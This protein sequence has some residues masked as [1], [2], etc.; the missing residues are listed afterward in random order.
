MAVA[1]ESEMQKAV[2]RHAQADMARTPAASI[3]PAGAEPE[4]RSSTAPTTSST[5]WAA[6]RQGLKDLQNIVLGAWG[7]T[8]EEPGSIANPTPLEVYQ[9]KHQ[10]TTAPEAFSQETGYAAQL[11][12]MRGRGSEDRSRGGLSR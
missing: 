2:T 4:G 12:Q 10:E 11:E 9:E 1:R 7:G 3:D 5:L 6:W 8:H